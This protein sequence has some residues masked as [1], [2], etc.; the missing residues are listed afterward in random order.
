MKNLL[1]ENMLRFGTKNLSESAKRQLVYNSIMADI[2]EYGLRES[3]LQ[4]LTEQ[5]GTDPAWLTT[6]KD[7]LAEENSYGY[8]SLGIIKKGASYTQPYDNW[9]KGLYGADIFA[10]WPKG[11]T[12]YMSPSLTVCWTNCLVYYGNNFGDTANTNFWESLN[13][14]TTLAQFAAGTYKHN[15]KVAAGVKS[16]VVWYPSIPNVVS[17]QGGSIL[18]MANDQGTSDMRDK[19]LANSTATGEAPASGRY[20]PSGK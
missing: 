14:P 4:H 8:L 11:A 7:A 15:G 16:N 1:S 20:T 3:V 12:W 10:V 9:A 6:A 5:T 17:S 19:L 2:N 13:N 18:K